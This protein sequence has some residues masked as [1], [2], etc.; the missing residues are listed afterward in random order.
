MSTIVNSNFKFNGVLDTANSVMDNLNILGNGSNCWV[1][2][3]VNSG[4]WSVII[5][6]AGTST[7]SFNDSNILGSITVSGTGLTE[8][9]NRVEV[10]FPHK[11]LND[12]K[13]YVSFK[14]PSEQLYSN[15]IAN[16]LT[17]DFDIIN[18]PIQAAL[19]GARELKQSRLD[20]IIKFTTDYS[21]LGLKAGDIIDVTAAMY[22]F[23]AK[24]F[25]VI[26][27]AEIDGD[28]GEIVLDITALEYSS[29]VYNTGGLTRVE[30]TRASG[31]ITKGV[32]QTL[33][34]SDNNATS[35]QLVNSLDN[36]DNS[37]LSLALLAA[38]SRNIGSGGGSITALDTFTL[39]ASTSTVSST[40]NAYS[41]TPTWPNIPYGGNTNTY[42]SMPF[43]V[44]ADI[45]TLMFIIQSPIAV[46]DYKFSGG[47]RTGLYAYA[48]ALFATYYN[49]TKIQENTGDWQTQSVIVQIPNAPAGN[50][51]FR[52][53]P[54]L[55]YDLDQTTTYNLYPFNFNVQP[56]ASGGGITIS[57][58]AFFQ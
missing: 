27:I 54:L 49:G 38:L 29:D 14:I 22:G 6:R 21:Q 31:I 48:P 52:V 23:N 30:R 2:M 47:T 58:Y 41:G 19:I 16:T 56:Q 35:S 39:V 5:N 7:A 43:T 9:Y 37:A 1:T 26:T 51:E 18:D 15:E 28:A 57:A 4:K 45:N 20:K 11:D 42:V 8:L 40:F 25:R 33:L 34:N 32:N 36:P 53:T 10:T 13:D 12:E 55:T 24:L 3:D 44:G 17:L 50:Y 46:Y